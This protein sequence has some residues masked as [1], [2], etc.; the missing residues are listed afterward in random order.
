MVKEGVG[1]DGSVRTHHENARLRKR[2]RL[3]L[4]PTDVLDITIKDGL[5]TL[6]EIK[7]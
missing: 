3:S 6:V 2:N 1:N 5:P 7:L 4:I